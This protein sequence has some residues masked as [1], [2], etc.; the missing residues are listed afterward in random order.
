[1]QIGSKLVVIAVAGLLVVGC[2]GKKGVKETVAVEDATGADAAGIGGSGLSGQGIGSGGP[3]DPLNQRVVYFDYDSSS[4]TPESQRVVEAHASY[5]A[6]NPGVSV[7]LEG[8]AD[9]RGTRE[10]NIA[11]GEE[12]AKSVG[13]LMQVLGVSESRIQNV[14]YGEERPAALGSDE[15]S[16][17]LNR[18]V[19]ILYGS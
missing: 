17:S 11:L 5:L 19:E 13:R 18:R 3:D 1:M 9:E 6:G 12:R 15:G 16:W 7:V 8:H 10:Y 14:S 4:L 2:A